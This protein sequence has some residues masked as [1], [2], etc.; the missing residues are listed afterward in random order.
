MD[1]I[2][3]ATGRIS[4]L[5]AS[6]KQYA[7]LGGSSVQE[8]DV[9]VGLDSTVVMLGHKLQGVRGRAGVRPRRCRRCRRTPPS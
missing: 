9:H 3:D 6:V 1:E 4:T 8:V 5:V 2:Q 7:Y